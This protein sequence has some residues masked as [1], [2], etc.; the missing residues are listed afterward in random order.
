MII[1]ILISVSI[2]QEFYA[3][4]NVND[5]DGMVIGTRISDMKWKNIVVCSENSIT[6]Y[7]ILENYS[8]TIIIKKNG[9]IFNKIYWFRCWKYNFKWNRCW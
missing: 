2:S 1:F 9:R 6:A 5:V 4:S 8:K 7:I 3:N